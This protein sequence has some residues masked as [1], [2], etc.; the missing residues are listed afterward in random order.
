[1]LKTARM[2]KELGYR[3]FQQQRSREGMINREE[4]PRDT[5]ANTAVPK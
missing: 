2:S 3:K 4:R 5:T 1:M